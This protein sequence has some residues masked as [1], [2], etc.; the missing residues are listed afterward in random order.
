MELTLDD[1]LKNMEEL[2]T[3]Y[4]IKCVMYNKNLLYTGLQSIQP[5][6]IT[7][8]GGKHNPDKIL[9][10]IVKRAELCEKLDEIVESYNAYRELAINK[11]VEYSK[12][13]TISEMIIIYR[14]K[15]HFK[16]KAIAFIV[17]Y[18]RAQVIRIYN[19]F[20]NETP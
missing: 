11:L 12:I 19:D 5:K 16:W 2:K 4:K 8:T 1:I 7:T 14:D 6:D 17:K 18:S 3:K 15:M 10:S 20:K 9:L 13:K